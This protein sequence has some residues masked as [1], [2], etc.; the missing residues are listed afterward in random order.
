M[1]HRGDNAP[2]NAFT[3]EEQPQKPG[4]VLVRFYEN[5][6]PFS[7]TVDDLTTSGYEYDEYYLEL[8]YYDGLHDDILNSFDSYF[9]E[10]KAADTGGGD[11]TDVWAI[12]AEALTEGV[13]SLDK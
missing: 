5:I 3:M 8:Q 11:D 13:N 1:K 4:F 2:P 9:A 6:V 10:A 12:M 7:Q